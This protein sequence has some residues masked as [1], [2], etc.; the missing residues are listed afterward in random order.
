MTY[1]Y[2]QHLSKLKAALEVHLPDLLCEA[3]ALGYEPKAQTRLDNLENMREAINDIVADL[4]AAIETE[5]ALVEAEEKKPVAAP[6]TPAEANARVLDFVMF[7]T[8]IFEKR[9]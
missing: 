3:T 7:G 2:R 1:R 5:K 9:Q 8:P 6:R 4:N